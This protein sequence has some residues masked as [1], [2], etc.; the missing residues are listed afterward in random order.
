MG[1]LGS[2]S[3]RAG[4]FQQRQVVGDGALRQPKLFDQVAHVQ[5]AALFELFQ[6]LLPD[7]VADRLKE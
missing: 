7:R 5:L 4:F 1:A 2:H 6:Y 3:D